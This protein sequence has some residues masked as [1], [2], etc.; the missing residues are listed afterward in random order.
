MSVDSRITKGVLASSTFQTSVATR[1]VAS[2][3]RSPTRP[4]PSTR[5]DPVNGGVPSAAV[6]TSMPRLLR[7]GMTVGAAVT[8]AGRPCGSSVTS[9]V[10]PPSRTTSTSTTT[11]PPSG[12]VGTA[13][14][15]LL[16]S[17]RSA[18]ASG[19][20][21]RNLGSG[22][23]ASSTHARSI[24]PRESAASSRTSSRYLPSAGGLN[25]IDGSKPGRSRMPP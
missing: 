23:R 24:P 17:A 5:N 22:L 16:G 20:T 4:R 18:C 7:A 10:K 19:T 9:P 11:R 21:S 14:L 1:A 2:R 15:S 3:S 13:R 12:S 8:P 25:V 6:S